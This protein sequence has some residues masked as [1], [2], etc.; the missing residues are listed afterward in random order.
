MKATRKQV[1]T[2]FECLGIK[3]ELQDVSQLQYLVDNGYMTARRAT[4]EAKKR[5]WMTLNIQGLNVGI[6][7]IKVI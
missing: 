5:L 4:H 3:Y 1:P 6:S 7:E 2:S